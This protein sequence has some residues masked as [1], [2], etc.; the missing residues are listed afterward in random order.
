MTAINSGRPGTQ[1]LLPSSYSV[2]FCFIRLEIHVKL[3]ELMLNPD[4]VELEV[5]Y[6]WQNP[7]VINMFGVL[8]GM[9][10]RVSV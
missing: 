6:Y 2:T 1:T 5:L 4:G 9:H 7:K 3:E 8:N 10:S